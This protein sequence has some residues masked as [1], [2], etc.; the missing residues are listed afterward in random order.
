MRQLSARQ[1]AADDASAPIAP[2]SWTSSGF[3]G[4][5]EV[6]RERQPR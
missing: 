6:A 3:A 5:K 1:P 4:L 2:D